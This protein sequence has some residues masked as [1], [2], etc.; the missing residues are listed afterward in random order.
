MFDPAPV[1]SSNSAFIVPANPVSD[2]YVTVSE[3]FKAKFGIYPEFVWEPREDGHFNLH[4]IGNGE[5][6]DTMYRVTEDA[7]GVEAE[8]AEAVIQ[9]Y[10]FPVQVV[11]VQD[12]SDIPF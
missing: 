11:V 9:Q 12:T 4:L 2:R 3:A 5:V 10:G 8:L 1:R 6:I 7:D